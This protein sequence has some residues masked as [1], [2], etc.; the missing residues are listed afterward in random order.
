MSRILKIAT[1]PVLGLGL[2]LGYQSVSGKSEKKSS[3]VSST[4]AYVT[5]ASYNVENWGKTGRVIKKKKVMAMKPMDEQEAVAGILKK[6][7]PDVLGLMEILRDPKDENIKSVRKTLKEAGLDYPYMA[8][9]VGDDE[10]IQNLLLSRLPIASTKA[11]NDD[12]FSLNV[13][14]Q[15]EGKWRVGKITRRVERGFIDAVIK[16]NPSYQLEI[17][18]AHLKSKRP[19][20]EFNDPR[21][22]EFGEDV[23]RRNEAL[24]LRSHMMDRYKENPEV[25]LLVMGDFNDIPT[26]ASSRTVLGN[27]YDSVLTHQLPLKDYLGDQW[28][29]FYSD[30]K[31]YHVIDYMFASEGLMTEFVPEKSYVYRE[32]SGDPANLAWA[33]ASDHRPLVAT[34]LAT[35]MTLNPTNTQKM[36]KSLN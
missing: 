3:R 1:L 21:T 19:V 27:S 2:V 6:I 14:Q 5:V 35:N 4:P 8:T 22:H 34:F 36:A 25:N 7:N 9:V 29:H 18:V 12:A 30:E 33:S 10:R 32:K 16:V 11:L 15:I 28:T 20:H 17:M 24:I 13:R 26:S 23:I 31:A